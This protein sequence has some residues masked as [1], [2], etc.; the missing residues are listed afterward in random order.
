MNP[1]NVLS[2]CQGVR[3]WDH[4]PITDLPWESPIGEFSPLVGHCAHCTGV[5]IA[6]EPN[7]DRM[8][9]VIGNVHRMGCVNT[10]LSC[11]DGRE[12]AKVRHTPL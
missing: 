7:R 5:L 6:N 9:A 1:K 2:N 11:L 8:R 4:P 3:I 10:V 12:M